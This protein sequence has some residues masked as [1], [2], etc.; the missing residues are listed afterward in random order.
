[1]DIESL[2]AA[3]APPAAAPNPPPPSTETP[4]LSPTTESAERRHLAVLFCDLYLDSA[5]AAVKEMGGHV[6]KKLG[7]GIMALFGYP[8]AQENVSE[9]A[10]RA[11]L[12]IQRA[13]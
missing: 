1:M 13:R 7:D 2:D 12:G 9:R 4:R 5:S 8:L 11:S 6:P 10:V 3:L